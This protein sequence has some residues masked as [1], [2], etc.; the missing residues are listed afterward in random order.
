MKKSASA[1]LLLSLLCTLEVAKAGDADMSAPESPTSAAPADAGPNML[2]RA[3]SFFG[4]SDA[5][6]DAASPPGAAAEPGKEKSFFGGLGKMF[7]RDGADAPSGKL[8]IKS[9][10]LV[11]TNSATEFDPECKS[12]VEPF[13]VT[14]NMASLLTLAAKLAL[15]NALQ[16]IAG[17]AKQDLRSTLRMAGKNLNWLPMEAE[18]LL[19]E[20]MHQE[21][22]AS[23]MDPARASGKKPTDQA[24]ALLKKIAAQIQEETPY[25]FEIYVR[26]NA[27]HNAKALP[28]GFLYLDQSLVTD[29]KNDD[30][31]AFALAHELAHVL[32]R[33]ETRATQARLTDGIDS[34]DGMR[35][36]LEGASANPA[37]I[38]AYS[39]DL[40]TRFVTFSKAQELQADACAVRLLDGMYPD[41]KR[42]AQVIRGFKSS[43]A[44]PAVETAVTNQLEMF[45][46]NM[47]KMDK[48]DEQHPNSIERSANLEKMLAEVG[49]PKKVVASNDSGSAKVGVVP[50]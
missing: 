42:L 19:G 20:R 21:Q 35:K 3:K 2:D 31:A 22:L 46:Q 45:V 8:K 37:A 5:S 14:D 23:I 39:N 40:M 47:Q 32:Q 10:D 25:H 38:V 29:K 27:G 12:L 44:P 33:H 41:K 28:G 50:R 16:P 15:N 26:R 13:G 7:N 11:F 1:L 24:N 34:V 48:L 30:L 6:G 4:K 18:R 17:G 43:L 49:K 9:I 36:L